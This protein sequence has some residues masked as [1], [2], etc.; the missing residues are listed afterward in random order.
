MT[1]PHLTL[2]LL[3]TAAGGIS[4][5]LSLVRRA[6]IGEYPQKRFLFR[7]SGR[8]KARRGRILPFLFD[9]LFSLLT[10][11]YLVLYDATV[12]GGSG[13]LYHLAVFLIGFLT[14]RYM[15]LSL[16]KE[17]TERV[18]RFWLDLFRLV[19]YCLF[20]PGRKCFSLIRSILLFS[21][22]I[23]KRKNDTMRRKR[24]AKREIARLYSDAETA[25]LPLAVTEALASGRK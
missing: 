11:C 6:C 21:Y 14:V 8:R 22:L 5:V 7:A 19:R 10:G 24:K 25:F 4:A 3:G 9:L 16:L 12:L 1:G 23:L 15:F 17:Q 2:F 13:R 18:F 20:Y